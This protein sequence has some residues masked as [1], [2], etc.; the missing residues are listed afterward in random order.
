M[1]Q[2]V[3]DALKEVTIVLIGVGWLWV[4]TQRL[5]VRLQADQLVNVALITVVLMAPAFLIVLWRLRVLVNLLRADLNTGLSEDH[6]S[7]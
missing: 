1:F 6:P 7:G 4:W 5:I 2:T 3:T